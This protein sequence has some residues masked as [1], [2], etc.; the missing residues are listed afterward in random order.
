MQ[1]LRDNLT[2]WTSDMQG[3]GD[4]ETKGEGERHLDCDLGPI[5]NAII[6]CRSVKGEGGRRGSPRGIIDHRDKIIII[7][8]IISFVKGTL[9]RPDRPGLCCQLQSPDTGNCDSIFNL[10]NH[11]F[12]QRPTVSKDFLQPKQILTRDSQNLTSKEN[13]CNF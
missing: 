11:Q 9:W 8:I 7:I 5:Y 2:L 4:T 10:C 1:L 12:G 3:E 6:S 13:N